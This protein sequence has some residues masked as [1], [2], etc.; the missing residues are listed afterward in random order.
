VKKIFFS[1]FSV[2]CFLFFIQSCQKIDTTDLGIGLI[3]AVDNINTF[4]T[5]LSVVTQNNYFIDT[6]SVSRTENHA[7]GILED[8]EFG[9]TTASIYFDI[10]PKTSGTYPF[11]GRDSARF[12]DSVV[13]SLNYI[14]LYGDSNSVERIQVFEIQQSADFRDSLYRLN[15]P[16]FPVAATPLGSKD[17]N[18][19]TLNDRRVIRKGKDTALVT[20]QNILAIHLDREFGRRLIN[21]DTVGAYKN[22]SAFTTY[23]KG[24]AIKVD[25]TTSQRKK[26]LGY[27]NLADNSKTRLTVYYRTATDT[28]FTEFVY[29][30]QVA[31]GANLVKRNVT[32]SRYANN[33]SNSADGNQQ[34]YIQS[35]PGSFATVTI[36]GLK[37]L[38][39]RIIH[40]AELIIEKLPS[41]DESF[42]TP[43]VLFIDMI[44]SAKKAFYTIPLDFST[45]GSGNYNTANFGG[46]IKSGRYNFDFSRHVQGIIT[47]KEPVFTYRLYAPFV[48]W[49]FYSVNSTT[50]SGSPL[51]INQNI[52]QGRVVVGGGSHP[53][54]KMR[55][56]IIYS[57]I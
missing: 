10:L 25:P 21:Y 48:T 3:P 11:I 26:A 28:A 20:E 29:K 51:L 36:P 31:K 23:V 55:L 34:V 19:T 2:F 9:T 38:T 30:N 57:K 16:D 40:K 17:V 49:P 52:A 45:D 43:P 33:I 22:D 12:I 50:Y 1:I 56:R 35:T 32:G 24:L 15:S 54:Q 41:Q 39:N 6:T 42:L 53:T 8:P 18:F 46:L 37:T 7:L 5:I 44:D 13:L 27:F 14:S 4:D 47:R